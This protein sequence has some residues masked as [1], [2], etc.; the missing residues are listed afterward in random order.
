MVVRGHRVQ[1]QAF[2]SQDVAYGRHAT[3]Y[4]TRTVCSLVTLKPQC[5]SRKVA[6]VWRGTASSVHA[7]G[8]AQMGRNALT[9]GEWRW[10]GCFAGS[11]GFDGGLSPAGATSAGGATCAA[12]AASGPGDEAG[13]VTIS[14]GQGACRR[15]VAATAP[16]VGLYGESA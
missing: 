1:H 12:G 10:R 13:A 11:C 6:A 7:G 14:T 5:V 3:V 8:G 9:P 2:G 15:Q 4:L 16:T